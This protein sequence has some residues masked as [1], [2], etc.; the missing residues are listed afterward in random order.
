MM[1]KK[2]FSMK[3]NHKAQTK[4]HKTTAKHFLDTSVARPLLTGA[5][6]YREY[7]RAQFADGRVYVS[8]FVKMELR[9]SFILSLINF[10]DVLD[11]ESIE[12][13]NDA[14]SLWSDRFKTSELKAVLQIVTQLFDT[15]QLSASNPKD[16][17]KA[18]MALGRLIKR[19][20]FEFDRFTDI[21]ADTTRC[22]RA[23]VSV[24]ID[25]QNLRKD[26]SAF[27]ERFNDT[28]TCR[29]HCVVDKFLLVRHRGTLERYIELGKHLPRG[30]Q[31]EGFKAI[32]ENLEEILTGGSSACTCK[33]CE[34]IG[35]AVIAL[36]TPRDLRLEHT[37]NSFNHLCPPLNQPHYHHP[38]QAGFFASLK[39][40]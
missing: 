37:D 24:N 7:L 38:S 20:Q 31:N 14:T 27:Y 6:K 9:R 40:S 26:I 33:R 13:I 17:G 35:D 19:Y 5:T 16:K 1:M 18:L 3:K 39:K 4:P 25:L 29:D 15:E 30:K 11:M 22:A 28:K 36:D 34:K 8:R 2:P 21:G 12:C 32:A 10:F 23:I